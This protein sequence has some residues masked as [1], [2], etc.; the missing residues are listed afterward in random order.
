MIQWIKIVAHLLRR[1]HENDIWRGLFQQQES[2]FAHHSD[3]WEKGRGKG[4]N[5]VF[6]LWLPIGPEKGI[7]CKVQPRLPELKRGPS[8]A[9]LLAITLCTYTSL[10]DP[11]RKQAEKR[12]QVFLK[13]WP[14]VNLY[15]PLIKWDSFIHS[16]KMSGYL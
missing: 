11:I 1:W 14:C 6:R 9:P 7:L 2:S 8:C 15:H 13:L 16:T 10:C 12:I 5:P 4:G 3:E